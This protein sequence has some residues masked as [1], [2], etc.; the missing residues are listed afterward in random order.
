MLQSA[1][2]VTACIPAEFIQCARVCQYAAMGFAAVDTVKICRR[3][4]PLPG[5]SAEATMQAICY[6]DRLPRQQCRQSAVGKE[7]R[8][9]G[10]GDLLPKIRVGANEDPACR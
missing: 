2:F 4:V 9:G 1:L 8:G 3:K 6:W 5:K 10:A 7:C